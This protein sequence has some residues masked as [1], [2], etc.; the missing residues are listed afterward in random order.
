MKKLLYIGL[1]MLAEWCP[2]PPPP[3]L[4]GVTFANGYEDGIA[5]QYPNAVNNWRMNLAQDATRLTVITSPRRKGMYALRV[6]VRPGDTL[7]QSGERAEVARMYG[8][9]GTELVENESSGT[10]YYGFSVMLPTDWKTT[11]DS[12]GKYWAIILQ[13]HNPDGLTTPSGGGVSPALAFEVRSFG[14]NADR[15]SLDMTTG[16]LSRSGSIHNFYDFSDGS[17]NLGKW[18]DFVIKVKYAKDATGTVDVWRRNEGS[19]SFTNVLSITNVPT[20][21]YNSTVDGGAV[22]DHYWS[23]GFYRNANSITNVLYLDGMTRGTDFNEVVAAAFP[24]PLIGPTNDPVI[25]LTTTPIP[26][27][28]EASTPTDTSTSTAAG[29]STPT[30]ETPTPTSTDAYTPLTGIP[31]TAPP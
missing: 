27:F 26:T 4:V 1:L 28:V 20:L 8:Y 10:Q 24:A 17:L 13:L 19:I 12:N 9:D 7:G 30:F 16:D 11:P 21:G 25:T 6:E 14:A 22:G 23:T 5:Y 29:T 2:M 3:P 31:T 15:F 18:T